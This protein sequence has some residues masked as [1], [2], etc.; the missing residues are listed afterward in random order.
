MLVIN[1]SHP[2]TGEQNAMSERLMGCAID[3]VVD[4]ECHL[5]LGQ[6]LADQVRA[7]V[8]RV[9]LSPSAWQTEPL[10]VNVPSLGAITAALLAELH[11]RTGHFPPVLRLSP[12]PDSIPT[13]YDVAEIL[14]LDRIRDEARQRRGSTL[15]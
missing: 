9:G 8:D 15:A 1:F 13:R 3:R 12:I 6:P 11:G 5:N 7:L 10:L 4:V 14:N 2:L